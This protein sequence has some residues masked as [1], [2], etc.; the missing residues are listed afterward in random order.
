MNASGD[1]R[2]GDVLSRA[3]RLFTG[4]ILFFLAVPFSIYVVTFFAVIIF[5][6]LLELAGWATKSAGLFGAGVFLATAL[7]L[8][9]NTVGQAVL[10]IGSIRRLR[11][12]PLSVGETLQK[13]LARLFPLLVLFLF[14][15]LALSLCLFFSFF[16]L[17]FAV[18]D[19]RAGGLVLLSPSLWTFLLPTLLL[20]A[21]LVPSAI[22][23]VMWA[24]AV[25][26]CVVEGRGP[27]ASMVRSTALTKGYRWKIF[28]IILLLGLFLLIGT[29]AQ[30][31]SA[32]P[33]SQFG[34][35][36]SIVWLVIWS[37]Y[38][39]CIIIMT[40]HDLRVAKEGVDTEQI[41]SIFD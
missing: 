7:V 14:W 41:A 11:G 21:S 37:G 35:V 39:N 16:T 20:L 30:L 3:W 15:S 19:S 26:A 31:F 40:Y 33:V 25:P 28:G 24:V 38:W 23:F 5:A 13:A 9:L 18:W 22:L 10:L 12:Q 17:S 36:V 8:G 2:V 27:F 4:S 1:F 29:F 34:T 32:G 6:R